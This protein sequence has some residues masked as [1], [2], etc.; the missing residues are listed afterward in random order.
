MDDRSPALSAS[1][2]VPL[3]TAMRKLRRQNDDRWLAQH[4]A[5][6][7]DEQRREMD[8]IR[9]V[10]GT[11]TRNAQRAIRAY[12]RALGRERRTARP[13][14]RPRAVRPAASRSGA[15]SATSG[16]DPGDDGEP[17][18]RLRVVIVDGDPAP[19]DTAV[20]RAFERIAREQQPGS[21]WTVRSV[22]G[23]R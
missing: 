2:Q 5:K 4:R 10:D 18:R 16:S 12:R 21:R 1:K 17:H 11:A 15:S 20:C 6:S 23:A 7:P 3:A 14:Q 19:G 9:D 22:G 13:R 8:T